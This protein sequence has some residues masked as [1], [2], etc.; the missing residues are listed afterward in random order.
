MDGSTINRDILGLKNDLDLMAYSILVCPYHLL[1]LY[2]PLIIESTTNKHR[3][4][5]PFLQEF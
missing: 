4:H 2:L 1:S 3:D 5:S